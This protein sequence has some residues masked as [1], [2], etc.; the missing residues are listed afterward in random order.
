LCVCEDG[1]NTTSCHIYF[2]QLASLIVVLIVLHLNILGLLLL[3]Q[4]PPLQGDPCRAE[5]AL[6]VILPSAFLKER[7]ERK[8]GTKKAINDP[9]R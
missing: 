1:E 5:I 2:S 6:F 8:K 7:K 4:L 9:G 3:A